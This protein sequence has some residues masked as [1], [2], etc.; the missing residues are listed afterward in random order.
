MPPYSSTM[1]AFTLALVISLCVPNPGLS[2]T[3]RGLL[4]FNGRGRGLTEKNACEQVNIVV[5]VLAKS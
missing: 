2:K 3:I 5:A 4:N 1:S